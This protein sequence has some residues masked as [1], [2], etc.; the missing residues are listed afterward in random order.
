MLMSTDVASI[1]LPATRG[2]MDLERDID[3]TTGPHAI[4]PGG[5]AT[6]RGMKRGDP[7]PDAQPTAVLVDL[8][9]ADCKRPRIDGTGVADVGQV[10][11]EHGHTHTRGVFVT[12][13]GFVARSVPLKYNTTG[14][15]YFK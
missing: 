7:E 9:A 1:I 12:D 13:S 8:A 4:A 11:G 15:I 14:L 5:P 6:V 2:I 10:R 3:T